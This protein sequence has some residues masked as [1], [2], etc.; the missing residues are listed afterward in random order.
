MFQRIRR[1]GLSIGK[2]SQQ[3]LDF[4]SV[5]SNWT[6][7]SVIV[8]GSRI[9]NLWNSIHRGI[10]SSLARSDAVVKNEDNHAKYRGENNNSDASHNSSKK[11]E[12]G[13]HGA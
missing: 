12:R 4:Q 1:G 6:C 9:S 8:Q 2:G 3:I 5:I 11:H 7:D 13:T 10:C